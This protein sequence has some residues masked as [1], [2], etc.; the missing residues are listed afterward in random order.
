MATITLSLSRKSDKATLNHEVLIEF[1]HGRSIHQRAKSN[2]FI[3]PD[4]WNDEQKTIVIPN[5]RLL[6]EDKKQI[7]E[8]LLQ[9]KSRLNEICEL[10]QKSFQSLDKSNVAKDWLKSLILDFN[11]PK[12]V[13]EDSIADKESFFDAFTK[14]ITISKFSDVRKRKM[15]C[16]IR[17]LQRFELYTGIELQFDTIT[18][19]TLR[20]IEE[21]YFDEPAICKNE[22]YDDILK[23]VPESR[24]PQ[25]RGGNALNAFMKCLRAFINWA[26]KNEY[27][28]NYPFK[29]YTIHGC[30][31]GT[32][33]FINKEELEKLYHFDFGNHPTL[34]RQRDIFVFQCMIGCRVSDLWAMT[35]SNIVDGILEYIPSKTKKERGETIRVPLNEIAREILERYKDENENRLLPFI[36]QQH[37]NNYIKTILQM[38]GIDRIVTKINPITQKE[39]Q[40]PIYEVASSHMAR[41]TFI[42]NLYNKVKDPN[43]IGKFTGH[44]EGSRAFC[45]YRDIDIDM[46][47]DLVKLLDF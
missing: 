34:A 19:D 21:F 7:K 28:T 23:A 14:Y 4:Y 40:R 35:N 11:F 37:Y 20:E 17:T 18:D 43:I 44:S 30:V 12:V 39:E 31:Y 47:K 15:R 36:S 38:A 27:T 25:P 22:Y 2:V 42:G 24:T 26:I 9:K 6:T 16:V 29:K 5:W 8:D 13:V 46:G 41:R 10:V 1:W 45:R 33:I 32:P 3:H